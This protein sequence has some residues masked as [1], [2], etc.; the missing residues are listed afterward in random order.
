MP[1]C[2]RCL[3]FLAGWLFESGR[4]LGEMY[5]ENLDI[6]PLLFW[7]VFWAKGEK[8]NFFKITSPKIFLLFSSWS[9][10][11]STFPYLY[12]LVRLFFWFICSQSHYFKDLSKVFF[13]SWNLFEPD[14]NE[15]SLK[16]KKRNCCWIQGICFQRNFS[17][18]WARKGHATFSW[19][20]PSFTS[21]ISSLAVRSL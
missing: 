5:L 14:I 8:S 21:T 16:R 6:F 11:K 1:V 19:N 20:E 4:I 18:K 10:K 17:Y 12:F 7:W 9:N 2:L 13:F 3:T 15:V